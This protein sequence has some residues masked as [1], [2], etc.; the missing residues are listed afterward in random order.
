MR[1]RDYFK[2]KIVTVVGLARSGSAC[3]N[4]L[5][6]LGAEVCVSD[7]QDNAATRSYAA[8]LEAKS[9]K[10]ELGGHS[11]EF[12]RNRDLVVVSPGVS[13]ISPAIIWA[14]QFKI[15]I[16]SEVELAWTLCPATVIATTGTNG[17]TTVTTLIGK[18]LEAKGE[19]V[20]VCGNIGNPFCGEVEKMQAGDYV[21]LEVSSFQL[22]RIKAF[23]PKISLILNFSSNH[24][25]R[26][27]GLKE[28]LQAKKRIFLN[29]GKSDYLVLNRLDP[30]LRQLSGETQAEVVYFSQEADTNLNQ[31]AVLAVG[32][33]LG[34]DE[35]LCRQVFSQFKGIEHRLE[36]VAEIKAVKFVND[37]KA[38]NVNSTIWALRNIASPVVLIAGGRGKGND[39]SLILDLVRQ[40]VKEAILIGEARGKITQAFR[41]VL[42]L[43]EAETLE[44]AV[45]KAFAKAAP[46]DCVLF[47][48][49]CKS[50]DMFANYEERGRVFKKAVSELTRSP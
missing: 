16:I 29:Q 50:F 2:D 5:S 47:S 20:F 15:P 6:D 9:I 12:I 39:Y 27:S 36:E 44:E 28:Y 31:A 33:I 23:Q 30:S 48:P 14:E 26:F 42:P 40:K 49:M 35:K 7:N 21:A 3:A 22:E 19:R 24:L 43:E 8:A 13:N 11:P 18:I 17:K 41:G 37:S 32:A 1:N 45:K 46:G 4:L 10:V 38:T 34:I 25:D